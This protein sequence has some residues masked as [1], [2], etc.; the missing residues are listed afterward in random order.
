MIFCNSKRDATG[1][2]VPSLRSFSRIAL[3]CLSA[4]GLFLAQLPAA[5]AQTAAMGA[6]IGAA[7]GGAEGGSSGSA[8]STGSQ[9]LDAKGLQTDR[10]S[11]V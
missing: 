2:G 5:Q 7:M 8:G 3:L 6:A 11:V 10:K 9:V 1:G 4:A